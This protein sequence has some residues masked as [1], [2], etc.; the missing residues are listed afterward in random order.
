MIDLEQACH[1][2]ITDSL[3]KHAECV[4]PAGHQ[5]WRFKLNGGANL[6]GVVQREN[7]WLLFEAP[8]GRGG[9]QLTARRLGQMLR[10]NAGLAG[11]AKCGL[12]E[13][14]RQVTL[15]A[16]IP[17][18]ADAEGDLGGRIGQVCAGFRQAAHRYAEGKARAADPQ[19][20]DEP[21]DEPADDHPADPAAAGP[22]TDLDLAGLCEQ[23]GWPYTRRANGQVTVPLEIRDAF[24]QALHSREGAVNRLSIPLA[25]PPSGRR[26]CRKAIE[27]LLLSACRL[28]RMARAVASAAD[29]GPEYRWEVALGEEP[30]PEEL[31]H[32][33]SALSVACRLTARE[34][35]A[36][37]EE[38]LAEEYLRVRG[39]VS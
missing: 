39:I 32:A 5:R 23:A 27:V 24:H 34:V 19:A 3:G 20:N 11:G 6:D 15:S 12:G 30:G 28:V 33:L 17:W 9:R 4:E 13:D 35:Q 25:H 31:R 16:E 26:T 29:G 21:A 7:D 10:D 22:A 14:P 38:H 37:E 2:A 8:L 36:L 1:T 18:D